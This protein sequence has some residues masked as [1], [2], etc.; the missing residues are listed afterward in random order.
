M[1]TEALSERPLHPSAD[2]LQS[3]RRTP[4][5]GGL[6]AVARRIQIA[7]AHGGAVLLGHSL[8]AVTIL[9]QI[10]GVTT[11]LGQLGTKAEDDVF[12]RIMMMVTGAH[13]SLHNR[14]RT[15]GVYHDHG[16]GKSRPAHR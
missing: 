3:E 4:S 1:N 9:D 13:R 12:R 2:D 6:L 10:E 15:Q 11:Y 16:G 14:L 5:R 8:A 7:P